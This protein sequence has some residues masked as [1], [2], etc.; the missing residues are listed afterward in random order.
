MSV[1]WAWRAAVT[2]ERA[3]KQLLAAMAQRGFVPTTGKAKAHATIYPDGDGGVLVMSWTA[4]GAAIAS[5]LSRALSASGLYAEIELADRNVSATTRAIAA[6][7]AVGSE[8]NRSDEA[9]DL[10]EEWFEGKKY[11][12][13]AADDLAAMFV[14][15]GD[16]CPK[17]G[18]E[19]AFDRTPGSGRVQS[20]VDAVTAGA[21]WEKTTMSGKAAIRLKD[22][23]GTRISVLDVA[24]LAAFEREVALVKK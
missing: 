16:G 22:S 21:T 3:K 8:T 14:D 13:E 19:L 5:T 4:G 1:T 23:S 24:E 18:V 9:S 10:C 7:G 15:V 12:S 6:N 20:L 17:E 11:R 2:V